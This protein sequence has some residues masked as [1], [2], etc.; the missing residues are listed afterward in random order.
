VRTR[1]RQAEARARARDGACAAELGGRRLWSS[2]RL[3]DGAR[4]LLRAAATRLALSARSTERIL[5]VGRTIADLADSP[6]VTEDH[7]S[8]ALAFRESSML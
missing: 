3:D 8:E 5:R 7:L 4:A 2:A 6:A 1:A